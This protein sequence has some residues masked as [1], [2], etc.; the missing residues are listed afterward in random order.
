[1]NKILSIIIPTYNMEEY[2]KRCLDSLVLPVQSLMN[3]LE[4]L[5]IIDG[6]TDN[7]SSIAH[8]YQDKCHPVRQSH[9]EGPYSLL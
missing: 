8:Q 9:P 5:V 2:L 1:M 4:V 3:S 7:S 6:A